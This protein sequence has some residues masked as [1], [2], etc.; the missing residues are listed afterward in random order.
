M[1]SG[2]RFGDLDSQ[3]VDSQNFS[4]KSMLYFSGKGHTSEKINVKH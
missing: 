2:F 1:I 3:M 4:L